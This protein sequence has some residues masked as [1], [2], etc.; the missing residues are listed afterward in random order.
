MFGFKRKPQR[1]RSEFETLTLEHMDALY[2]AAL[3]LTRS[4][5]D[6]EDLVQDTFLKAFRFFDSFEKGTNIKAWL[7]KIQ[8]NTFINKYR[9]KVKEREV[10]DTPA[11]DVV[12]DRFVS[13]EQVRALQ[14]PEGDFFG[15]LLSDE[16]VEA[17]DQVPVDFRMV[18]ILADIQ[19][20]SYKEIAEIVG[21]PVGT[22]MSRLFRGRRI[23]QKHLY[24]YA[25]QEGIISPEVDEAGDAIDLDSYR[26]R[27]KKTA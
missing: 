25:I 14:D 1:N 27:R 20:F 8:T 13:S 12:L 6:A 4:P 10:A 21:C 18:V 26:E 24:E 11:E 9:R 2:G 22:V 23:L 19:G 5:K 17:L 16:V 3:R 15:K 7:F